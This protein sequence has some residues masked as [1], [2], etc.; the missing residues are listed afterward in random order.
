HEISIGDRLR[1]GTAQVMV[2]QPRFPC[3]KL[4]IKFG[5]TDMVKRFLKSRLT[6]FYFCVLQEGEVEAGDTLELISQDEHQVTVAD[7][8]RLYV[9]ETDDLD[10]LERVIQVEALPNDWR[11][12]FQQQ[13]ARQRLL[14]K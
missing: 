13:L 10:L 14:E 6:G 2:T 7:F 9:R 1:I 8:A 4:G 3:Y 5:R 11:D 12:Y